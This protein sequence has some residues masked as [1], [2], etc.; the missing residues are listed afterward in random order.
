MDPTQTTGNI[1][2]LSIG[3]KVAIAKL[4]R[5]AAQQHGASVF[6]CDHAE[7][8][9]SAHFVDSFQSIPN[10]QT[11]EYLQ[12]ALAYCQANKVRLLIPTRHTDLHA[13]DDH[14]SAFEAAGVVLALSAKPTL[15]ICLDKWETYRFFNRH[16]IPTPDTSN[17]LEPARFPAYAKRRKGS[18]S[19]SVKRL[20]NHQ[21][22][23][24]ID[25]EWIFQTPA[26]GEEFTINVYID[27]S[28]KCACCIPHHRAIVESGEVN[29][30]I[31]RH[32]PL[33]V[34]CANTIAK[35]LEGAWGLLN[36][37][38]FYDK[39]TDTCQFIEINPRIG[40][41]YPL[42]HAAGGRYLD[43]LCNE[44]FANQAP[45]EKTNWTR[46]LRMLRYRDAIFSL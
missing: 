28:G 38:A 6:A 44:V 29:Q 9:P 2:L 34:D 18:G 11:S 43:W 27:R 8:V 19:S 42:A 37:Q 46:N 10:K 32:I 30:A 5:D 4:A 25:G 41:G 13:L 14:R 26:V 23:R 7:N 35:H 36:I 31:T 12:A 3:S 39:T 33:L 15:R 45:K 24:D 1:L 20:E 22:A 40:G 17:A 16:G 21:E